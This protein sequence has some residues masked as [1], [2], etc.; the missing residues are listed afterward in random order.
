MN[1]QADD[2][3]LRLAH[4]NAFDGPRL[5][6]VGSIDAD[7]LSLQEL[8]RQL[9]Q[10]SDISIELHKQPFVTSFQNLALTLSSAPP[11]SK[12]R[13]GLH[14]TP[15]SEE[16]SFHWTLTPDDWDDLVELIDPVVKNSHPGHQYLNDLLAS[17]PDDVATVVASKGE[18]G[19]D[20]L[21]NSST[22]P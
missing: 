5:M 1:T 15:T 4:Y 3:Q 18:Y 22:K 8:F 13:R 9:S 19:D 14:R 10:K 2:T 6:I 7:F 16:F 21:R 12:Y 17:D 20:I 11:K